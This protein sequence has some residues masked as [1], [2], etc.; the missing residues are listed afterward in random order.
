MPRPRDTRRHTGAT[1]CFIA[2]ARSARK[3]EPEASEQQH[4]EV[5]RWDN[6]WRGRG[7]RRENTGRMRSCLRK[8]QRTRRRIE[9]RK[10][11]LEAALVTSGSGSALPPTQGSLR[12]LSLLWSRCSGAL[13]RGL[14]KAA[15]RTWAAAEHAVARAG[16]KPACGAF[17]LA[18]SCSASAGRRAS[19]AV[20]NANRA[21]QS[22]AAGVM[23][24]QLRPAG[25]RQR[26]R[27][28]P[29]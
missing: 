2:D 5:R 21:L 13:Q 16:G 27:R 7:E 26:F 20:P 14:G 12:G 6:G 11:R 19:S 3:E 24:N 4:A 18:R 9:V 23:P 10:V 28:A 29:C 25:A 17:K 22:R 15:R 1:A 8:K